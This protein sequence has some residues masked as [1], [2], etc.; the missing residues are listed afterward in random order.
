M[1]QTHIKKKHKE[2][3]SS[4]HSEQTKN[5]WLKL[6][7]KETPFRSPPPIYGSKRSPTSDRYNAREWHTTIVR[8]PNPNVAFS[9]L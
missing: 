9:H 8:G 6:G 5:Q 4:I 1:R 3:Y 2:R 7:R